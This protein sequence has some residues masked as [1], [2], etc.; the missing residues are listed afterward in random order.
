MSR[1]L[2]TGGAGF[3]GAYVARML[4]DDGCTVAAADAFVRYSEPPVDSAFAFN[5]QYRFE[6]LLYDIPI[7]RCDMIDAASLAKVLAEFDPTHVIHLA[8]M[9]LANLAMRQPVEAFRSITVTTANLLEVLR[10][11]HPRTRLI[12]I[13]SSM[14][15]G[16]FERFP[17]DEDARL[18]PKE[19][20]GGMK[21]AGEQIVRTYARCF[22]IPFTIIRPCSVYGPGD[23]N[24]RV[25]GLFLRRAIDGLPIRVKNADTTC[26]DFTHVTDIARGLRLATFADKAIGETFNITRGRGRTLR[27]AVELI[28]QLYP[29]I[30]IEWIS[31]SSFRPT[32]GAMDCSKAERLLGYK[33][34]VDLEE[35]VP[36]YARFLE[37]A[38][39]GGRSSQ[40][41][42]DLPALKMFRPA[43]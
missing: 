7:L 26:L 32:R 39:G 18:E 20:Y 9:P 17:V 3:I 28:Q 27:E 11:R 4:A 23:N 19:I 35:G 43:A 10:Q 21:L 40:Q 8:G 36:E 12:H 5:E 16:D 24:R 31:E 15:Y 22:D 42:S 37:T 1:V 41:P 33:P 25:L 14:T 30:E 13:S 34:A 29:T 38:I 6:K 2:I